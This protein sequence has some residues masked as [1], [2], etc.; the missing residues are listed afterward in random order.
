MVG[1]VALLAVGAAIAVVLRWTQE[2]A[3]SNSALQNALARRGRVLCLAGNGCTSIRAE[4]VEW[5]QPPPVLLT[6]L[7][8]DRP[9][10][11][12]PR[13]RQL[14]VRGLLVRHRAGA[15]TAVV[16]RLQRYETVQGLRGVFLSDDVAYYELD[17][18]EPLD[19][20]FGRALATVARRMLEGAD[21]PQERSFPDVLRAAEQSEVLVSLRAG[22][23]NR[24]W[25]SARGSSIA[26]ALIVATTALKARWAER[27]QAMGETLEAAM[28]HLD[29]VVSVMRDDGTL[30]ARRP[31]VFDL[32]V[33]REHGV[34]YSD[35]A[36]W[37]YSLPDVV[38]SAGGGRN[39][40][41]QLAHDAHESEA[42]FQR[43]DVRVY[44]FTVTELGASSP[45][46]DITASPSRSPTGSLFASLAAGNFTMNVDPTPSWVR[47]SIEP[48]TA[49]TIR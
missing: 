47:T 9:S 19:P 37:K 2:G 21:A 35:R 28:S 24:M 10:E 43:S 41:R 12:A 26:E 6:K 36:D 20:I 30:D 29:V 31:H 38:Q 44:R 39:A 49:E 5:V 8:D 18:L 33:Q 4:G 13:L 46:D 1:L 14:S 3:R 17:D 25:R 15:G 23:Q 11:V 42:M 22:Q 48:P 34:G 7:L 16:E 32:A 45:G 27:A 40:L